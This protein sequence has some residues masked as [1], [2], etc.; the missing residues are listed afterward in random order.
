MKK[1][2]S[3]ILLSGI[4]LFLG[5]RTALAQLSSTGVLAAP[6]YD[7]FVPPATGTS[8]TDP[9]FGS[10]IKRISNAPF[11]PNSDRGGML[12]WIENE[13]STMSAFN[14][15]NSKFILVH[16]SYFGLYNGD[17]VY[18]RDLPLEINSSSEPRWSRKDNETLY[19]HTGNRFKSYNITTGVANVVHAFSEYSSI[20]G[21]GEMDI[22][23][24]GDH[25][26]FAG[27][28]R[29]IFVY[30]IST[31]TK[32]RVFDTNGAAFDATYVTPDN[33]VT[34]TWKQSGT[35][36]F[37][38]IELF[39]TNMNFL[40]QVA[41]VG[42][43]MDVTRDTNG[44]EVLVW[45]NSN[46]S[47]PIPNCNNGIVKI[48]LADGT[49]TCLAQLDWSLAVHIS[50]PD[51][52]G[53]VFVETYA[54]GNPS[55][56]STG[57]VP[58]TN[59]LL[60]VKLDA[61]GINRLA[62]HRSRPWNSYNYEPKM[63][64]SRDGSRVLFAS[65][66]DLQKI[67]SYTAEYSDTYLMVLGATSSTGSGN[68]VPNPPPT[69]TATNTRLEQDNSAAQYSGTWYPN[70][71]GFNSGGSATL[72]MNSGDS[73]KLPFTGTGVKWIGY[74]D[75]WSGIA[76]VYI[77]G[78]LKA[79]LDTYSANTQAQKAQYS[80]DGLTNGAHTLNIVAKGQHSATSQ[81]A[82]VWIDAF[83]VT[84]GSAPAAVPV[85]Q[86]AAATPVRIEQNDKAIVYAGTWAANKTAP[87]TA[88]S[89]LSMDK[90]ARATLTFTGTGVTWI[91]YRDQW[92]G[93]AN[94]YIDGVLKS[95]VNTYLS[96]AAGKTPLYA[97]TGLPSGSH[98]LTIEVTGTHSGA[99]GGS[100]IWVD[101]FDVMP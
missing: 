62:H 71:G 25:F 100:W 53:T 15:D 61:S 36:R 95:K 23:F 90:N 22:S 19:Y 43:H 40:R 97:I 24:D 28:G 31:D 66:Y 74:S 83:D 41:H 44:D 11:T 57:W 68:P 9:V 45:T 76:E 60:Q 55:P 4:L 88:G 3:I 48:R 87:S 84:A 10:T 69:V 79:T 33:N 91:G 18:V 86:P 35:A 39:D 1:Q 13:Y 77:D 65:N 58:Y 92:S 6:N 20:S 47:Q 52:N 82:W 46:D 78:A 101:A 63:S 42:G 73:V 32:F 2:H 75:P 94:V 50:A 21:N 27:D 64:T 89:V 34:I 96:P 29:Y 98:T 93:I 16:E 81:G 5:S 7:S 99:S 14:N 54:P 72:A 49:Q 51:G 17:G 56:D 12:N 85:P 59:E 38:G 70:R 37:S 8:Y 80:V 67:D 26:V 30:Q